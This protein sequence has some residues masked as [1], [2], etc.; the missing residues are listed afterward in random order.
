MVIFHYENSFDSLGDEARDNIIEKK[1]KI[2]ATGSQNITETSQMAPSTTGPEQ[3]STNMVGGTRLVMR[4]RGFE[5]IYNQ[6]LP[7]NEIGRFI[8][9]QRF[10]AFASRLHFPS[11]CLR[12]QS[13]RPI[14]NASSEEVIRVVTNSD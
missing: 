12:K 3:T 8:Y 14:W 4:G 5:E 9:R 1:R 2:G 7:L 13:M 6:L 11:D 10:S